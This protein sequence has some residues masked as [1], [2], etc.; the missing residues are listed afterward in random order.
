MA[1]AEP[2]TAVPEPPSDGRVRI[3]RGLICLLFSSLAVFL[4]CG[5]YFL[6]HRSLWMDEVHTSLLVTDANLMHAVSALRDGVDFNPPGYFLLARL[7]V[8]GS[9][10]ETEL[11]LRILSLLLLLSA[12]AGCYLSAARRFGALSAGIAVLFAFGFPNVIHQSTEVRFYSLWTAA[13]IWLGWLLETVD[14]SERRFL[15][16][17][18]V[19]FLAVVVCTC[20]YFGIISLVLLA[21]GLFV[22]VQCTRQSMISSAL[23]MACGP[24]AVALCYPFLIG[25]RQALTRP[26]WISEPTLSDSF[27]FLVTTLPLS[28]GV[29]CGTAAALTCWFRPLKCVGV[30]QKLRLALGAPLSTLGLMP[31]ILIAFS[32]SFQP[33]MVPRYAMAGVFGC[34]PL[35]AMAVSV[36]GRSLRIITAVMAVM[37]AS[38]SVRNCAEQW[39]EVEHRLTEVEREVDAVS[40]NG[41]IVFEDRAIWLP[42]VHKRRDLAD[43]CFL[44]DFHNSQLAADSSLRIVQRDVGRR[45]SRWYPTLRMCDLSSLK[46]RDRFFVVPYQGGTDQDLLYPVTH[47]SMKLSSFIYR[48]SKIPDSVAAVEP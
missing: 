45:M 39:R 5:G 13:L 43:R 44:A 2:E 37:M 12:L 41:A 35:M 7:F 47:R 42:L 4:T 38:V 32:W 1:A 18:L 24:M 10:A 17:I 27:G 6:L 16:M 30:Q 26:T 46:D 31:L 15:R 19:A 33:A 8:S 25:Q 11:R 20:H 48:F 3:V 22:G 14:F 36:C 23:A 9:A 28:A 40:E 34:V 29:V 21:V